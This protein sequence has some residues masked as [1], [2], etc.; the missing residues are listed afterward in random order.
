MGRRGVVHH[1]ASRERY[2]QH[3]AICTSHLHLSEQHELTA[4]SI[5]HIHTL[6]RML[7]ERYG[8]PGIISALSNLCNIDRPSARTKMGQ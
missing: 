6:Y 1:Y 4:C 3:D 8:A 5:V 2:I 7:S